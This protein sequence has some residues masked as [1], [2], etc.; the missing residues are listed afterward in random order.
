MV[1]WTVGLINAISFTTMAGA[2]CRWCVH[3]KLINLK[4]R[5]KKQRQNKHL[6]LLLLLLKRVRYIRIGFGKL[7][8]IFER[9]ERVSL[10]HGQSRVQNDHLRVLLSQWT[11]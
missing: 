3:T 11:R 8:H 7:K 6:L 5:E 2:F 4:F 9:M 10:G 1:M